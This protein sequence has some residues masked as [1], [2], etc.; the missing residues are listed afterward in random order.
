MTSKQTLQVLAVVGA[1]SVCACLWA[2]AEEEDSEEIDVAK[3]TT[4]LAKVK[5]TFSQAFEIATKTLPDGKIIGAEIEEEADATTI[6]VDMLKGNELVEV[7][8][9]GVSGKVLKSGPEKVE[10]HEAEELKQ[11]KKALPLIKT[12]LLDAVAAAEKAVPGGK[13]FEIG[14][15]IEKGKAIV[16]VS[17]LADAKPIGVDVDGVTGKVLEQEKLPVK[18]TKGKEH[19]S[20]SKKPIPADK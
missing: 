17:V 5:I 15:E 19:K 18:G 1:V 12:P 2:R 14:L 13:T 4:A 6:D 16:N 3:T 7:S 11:A 9:D 8:L 20:Q 10:A